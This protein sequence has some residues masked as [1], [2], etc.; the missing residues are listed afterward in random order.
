MKREISLTGA[1]VIWSMFAVL[2]GVEIG[3]LSMGWWLR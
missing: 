2:A 1:N 3:L